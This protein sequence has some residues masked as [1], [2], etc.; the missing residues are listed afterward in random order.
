MDLIKAFRAYLVLT[1]G[2][3]Q[4]AA[5][6]KVPD[7][8]EDFTAIM[9]DLAN[10]HKAKVNTQNE[11]ALSQGY[12]KGK[13]ETLTKFED[14]VRTKFGVT[15]KK[16]GLELI[17]TIIADKTP[18]P[19][20]PD[21]IPADVVKKHPA[22]LERERDLN[23]QLKTAKELTDAEV[24]KVKDEYSQKD[25]LAKV[26]NVALKRFREMNP[27]L[28]A[29]AEKAAR[30]EARLVKE[31]ESLGLVFKFQE[32]QDEPLIEQRIEGG[33]KRKED[34][35]GN[36]VKF[37]DFVRST[38]DNMGFVFKA[39]DERTDPGGQPPG[40]TPPNQQGAKKYTGKLPTNETEYMAIITNDTI[41]L[42][43]RGEVQDA[44][45]AS[46]KPK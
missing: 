13:L 16:K 11:E 19:A 21:A 22:F 28:P 25:T 41:P 35:H 46:Q 32:G 4:A 3:T 36:P 33:T 24:Q 8:T 39:A 45:E 10:A 31:I 23:N 42:D 37:D 29:D 38:A 7:G 14:D 43:Q 18:D 5:E 2:L 15:S 30:Q 27:D 12:N 1:L 34:G 20:N 17:E 9:G 44:W 26:A 6:A 40:S